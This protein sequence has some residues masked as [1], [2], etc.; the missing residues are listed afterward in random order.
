MLD[1]AKKLAENKNL[2]NSHLIFFLK[3]MYFT[4]VIF[5]GFKIDHFTNNKYIIEIKKQANFFQFPE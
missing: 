1:K 2:C 5:I 3:S 4:E